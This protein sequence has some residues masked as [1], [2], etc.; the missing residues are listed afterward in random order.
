MRYVS[1]LLPVGGV[2]ISLAAF[3]VCAAC[4]VA[5]VAADYATYIG[6][7][8]KYSVSAIASD[9]NGNTYV[10]G[11]R[12]VAVSASSQGWLNDIFVSK[13]DPDG[14]LTLLATLS[15]K[16]SDQ[17]FGI[18]LDPSGN[19]YIVGSTSSPDFPLHHP[20]QSTAYQGSETGFLVK[21]SADGT[22]LYSTYLG[23]TTGYSTMN[24]VVADAGG[25]AYVTGKTFASDYQHTTGLP[26]GFTAMGPGGVSAAFFA[27]ISAAGDKPLWNGRM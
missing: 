24:A 21:L 22:I 14:N 19:I 27:K 15:G 18:A 16:G 1:R 20:L 8:Y 4:A 5:S 23:G 3:F 17:A 11:S 25:N 6:D 12:A 26:A 13:L 10:T 2:R 9:A 7:A